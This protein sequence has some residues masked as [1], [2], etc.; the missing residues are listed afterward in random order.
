MN[1]LVKPDLDI[2]AA[3]TA[4]GFTEYETEDYHEH[5]FIAKGDLDDDGYQHYFVVSCDF[6]AAFECKILAVDGIDT[7]EE[8]LQICYRFE[9]DEFI[10]NSVH[11]VLEM[12]GFMGTECCG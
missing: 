8:F 9:N 5:V 6:C 11:S 2:R 1:T 3:L 10:C 12:L 7:D 4:R